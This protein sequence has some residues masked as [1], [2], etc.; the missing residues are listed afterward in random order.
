MKSFMRRSLAVVMVLAMLLTM[1][2]PA[3]AAEAHVHT[4]NTPCEHAGTDAVKIEEVAATCQKNGGKWHTCT[5][6][7]D[8][9]VTDE[10]AKDPNAHNMAGKST[11]V[12][13]TCW[14]DGYTTGDY[15]T[16]EGCTY[17]TGVTNVVPKYSHDPEA[18]NCCLEIKEK[19]L[20]D[21]LE[22]GVIIYECR[23]KDYAADDLG[24]CTY[25]G[26]YDEIEGPQGHKH[27]LLSTG[28]QA[29]TCHLPGWV[30]IDCTKCDDTFKVAIAAMGHNFVEQQFVPSSCT[31][32]GYDAGAY[33][34]NEWLVWDENGVATKVTCSAYYNTTK[35]I[36]SASEP[37]EPETD[38]DAEALRH[39]ATSQHNMQPVTDETYKGEPAY[40]QAMCGENEQ[41]GWQWHKCVDC[42][43]DYKEVL[44]PAHEEDTAFTPVVTE[45]TCTT[46]GYT[47]HKCKICG[48]YYETDET[49]IK[50]AWVSSGGNVVYTFVKDGK[51]FVKVGDV[52]ELA[53]ELDVTIDFIPY[54]VPAADLATDAVAQQ[55]IAEG[56][57]QV[58]WTVMTA[59]S[60]GQ[61][62]DYVHKCSKCPEKGFLTIIVDH[63]WDGDITDVDSKS[64]IVA[65]TCTTPGGYMGTCETCH[66][67]FILSAAM[68]GANDPDYRV[69]D[70]R[71]TGH[72][73]LTGPVLTKD[74]ATNLFV[75]PRVNEQPATCIAL[76]TPAFNYCNNENCPDHLPNYTNALAAVKDT[77]PKVPHQYY[78][79]DGAA[80]KPVTVQPTC[81][82]SGFQIASCATCDLLYSDDATVNGGD[83]VAYNH[84]IPGSEFGEYDGVS[85]VYPD[86]Y[87]TENH[88]VATA[89]TCAEAGR[90]ADVQCTL[91]PYVSV[92]GPIAKLDPGAVPTYNATMKDGDKIG[93][94]VVAVTAPKCTTPGKVEVYCEYCHDNGTGTHTTTK[95]HDFAETGIHFIAG[96]DYVKN[97]DGSYK[98]VK[99]A[100][101]VDRDTLTGAQA[102]CTAPNCATTHVANAGGCDESMNNLHADHYACAE[103]GDVIFFS[104]RLDHLEGTATC[105]NPTTCTECNKE[106]VAAVPHNMVKIDPAVTVG[107]DNLCTTAFYYEIYCTKCGFTSQNN[108]D[109]VWTAE[110]KVI[111]EY[112]EA[113]DHDYGE[114]S[115][116]PTCE[117]DQVCVNDGCD[118]TNATAVGHEN[119]VGYSKEY[120]NPTCIAKGFWTIKCPAGEK[121]DKYKAGV[122]TLDEAGNAVWTEIDDAS[123]FADHDYDFNGDGVVNADDAYVAQIGDCLSYNVV[124]YQCKDCYGEAVKN[125]DGF[126]SNGYL[127]TDFRD[128]TGHKL[129]DNNTIEDCD[130]GGCYWKNCEYCFDEAK[131][132]AGE[133]GMWNTKDWKGE[134]GYTE[135][136]FTEPTGHWYW[137]TPAVGE[138]AVKIFFDLTCVDLTAHN[139]PTC[140]DCGVQFKAEDHHNISKEYTLAPTCTTTGLSWKYCTNEGCGYKDIL[141]VEPALGHLDTDWVVD[142]ESTCC[143]EGSAHLVCKVCNAAVKEG[144][145]ILKDGETELVAATAADLTKSLTKLPHVMVK[146]TEKSKDPTIHEAGVLVKKCV[147]TSHKCEHT[148]SQD[149]GKLDAVEFSAT[150]DNA[151]KPGHMVFVN[152][153]TIA[154]TISID[155]EAKALWGVQLGVKF[156][157]TKLTYVGYDLGEDNA[158]LFGTMDASGACSTLVGSSGGVVSIMAYV[159]NT[160]DAT[161]VDAP[162]N[163]KVEF[164]TLYFKINS[165]T[166][167]DYALDRGYTTNIKIDASSIIMTNSTP[168][169][170]VGTSVY[171]AIVDDADAITVEKLGDV[172]VVKNPAG[173]AAL[174][175]GLVNILDVQYV[176]NHVLSETYD[177]RA[178]IN[179]DGIVNVLDIVEI[180]RYIIFAQTYAQMVAS[181]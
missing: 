159:N 151:V 86:Y 18:D 139:N 33:C 118:Y 65:P 4:D 15:C 123:V 66:E 61:Q 107:D 108:P 72:M 168:E 113:Q 85:H 99:G 163:E 119:R 167:T 164:V 59:V 106:L 181:N 2:L 176:Q 120:T 7:G 97:E 5:A 115:D 13:A 76:G 19:T 44:Q 135:K 122:A 55:L 53:D 102:T 12:E 145:L 27:E 22:G 148:T 160:A 154:Y 101:V 41:P 35:G 26:E 165:N 29:P 95:I 133:D 81:M 125:A 51:T 103:C 166:I 30:T 127:A 130:E 25:N 73:S 34:D 49:P 11:T 31:L 92:G 146:D 79:T 140:A 132:N 117:K 110:W 124:V 17:N 158:N 48:G 42:D 74:P 180:Q 150:I 71:A 137:S 177:A 36:G 96:A 90:W 57:S 78:G 144:E 179:Q 89:P 28:Y 64:D 143:A 67:E 142:V 149:L 68:V 98:I 173:N 58:A 77:L 157:N 3:F 161:V 100:Y 171:D 60:C 46:K 93:G 9:W 43:A 75:Y 104:V 156:D 147:S 10:V 136:R 87:G 8:V 14:R 20:A 21:C 69:E 141:T 47:T 16:N 70:Y 80:L 94:W 52:R 32:A 63:V 169:A 162:V 155:A 172:N 1:A 114:L 50:H 111:A 83:T 153:G 109:F 88:P 24:S 152:G 112:V 82:Y 56:Y 116:G 128:P 129:V 62:G 38:L 105:G 178:D 121:C 175:D 174:S 6:C 134:I 126:I 131:Y 54:M 40:Q 91:C 84:R 170:E 23:F 37:V 39:D 138:E 45:P